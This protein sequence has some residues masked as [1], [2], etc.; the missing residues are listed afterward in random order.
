M[1]NNP[2][3]HTRCSAPQILLALAHLYVT[4]F[5]ILWLRPQRESQPQQEMKGWGCQK[6]EPL[7]SL[8]EKKCRFM[9]LAKDLKHNVNGNSE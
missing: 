7:T 5:K 2:I 6:D 9:P 4:T 3:Y 1:F 8:L